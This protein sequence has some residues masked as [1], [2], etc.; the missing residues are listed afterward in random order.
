M[1]PVSQTPIPMLLT[2]AHHVLNDSVTPRLTIGKLDNTDFGEKEK[3]VGRQINPLVR[4]CAELHR[5]CPV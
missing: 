5:M 4:P 2:G 3:K 1:R